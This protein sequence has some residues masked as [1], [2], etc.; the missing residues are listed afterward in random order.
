MQNQGIS[1]WITSKATSLLLYHVVIK[2][3]VPETTFYFSQ[4][5]K[6]RFATWIV[7]TGNTLGVYSTREGSLVLPWEDKGTFLEAIYR[8]HQHT[9]KAVTAA[10]D[11]FLLCLT[12]T[13]MV[14]CWVVFWACHSPPKPLR[15]PEGGLA[16]W[17]FGM[18][19]RYWEDT[20]CFSKDWL[21]MERAGHSR[22]EYTISSLSLQQRLKNFSEKGSWVQT[23]WT[24]SDTTQPGVHT[25]PCTC[26]HWEENSNLIFNILPVFSKARGKTRQS[27]L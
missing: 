2:S 4:H 11:S 3:K 12:Q 5:K 8:Q 10:F 6:I 20:S 17:I 7:W 14:N 21:L 13:E 25:N 24:L 16:S 23:R 26:L 15:L 9:V 1:T 22:K 18:L 27:L 19:Q